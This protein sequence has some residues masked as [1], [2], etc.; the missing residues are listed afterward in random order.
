MDTIENVLPPHDAEAEQALLGSV[1]IDPDIF[2]EVSEV[3]TA[4]MFYQPRNRWLYEAIAAINARSEPVDLLTVASELTRADRLNETGGQDYIL[5][6]I[7]A[8]PTSMNAEYYAGIVAEKATRRRLIYAAGQVAKAAYNETTPVA[9]AVA[10]AEAAVFGVSQSAQRGTV[11]AP[12]RF[13]SDYIDG[14]MSDVAATDSPHVIA[15][16]L[17]DLDRAL[18]GLEKPHQYLIAGR[19]SMGKSSL[20]LEIA[21]HA[22]MRQSKRVL[23]FSLEMS[24]EQIINRLISLMTRIPVERLRPA[25]RRELS[26]A[27][28]SAVLGAGGKLADSAIFLDCTAGLKPTDIRSRAARIYAAHGLDMMIVDHMHIM[29]ASNPTGKQVQDLG[30]ISI[31]LANIYKEFNVAGLTLA[32]LN[33]GVDARAIKRPMLSDL[34]ESGQIEE[35][36]YAV[37]FVHRD[38]Y[39]DETAAVGQAEIIIAKNRDGATGSVTVGWKPELATFVNSAGFREVKL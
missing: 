35:N 39:Y 31:E 20:A 27:E 10:A 37:L 11:E 28:Q 3:I 15:T 9:E 6:L 13:M 8:V 18:G 25:R 38:N 26:P 30:A 23:L 4:D 19:T 5:D 21:L 29:A 22:A 14:F 7:N 32:Q 34:R 36:A 16:G 24:R 17:I 12:R 1:L 2:F 33:R